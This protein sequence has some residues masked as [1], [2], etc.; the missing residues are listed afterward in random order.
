MLREQEAADTTAWQYMSSLDCVRQVVQQEGVAGLYR[1]LSASYYLGTVEA[2][3]RTRLR[4]APME[5]GAS[6]MSG[7]HSVSGRLRFGRA[8]WRLDAA[9][10]DY[11]F[12]GVRV[13]VSIIPLSS[14]IALLD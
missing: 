3:L 8:L 5:K 11:H 9:L 4:Q 7:S 1:G 13:R 6:S 12:K 10:D 14:R 2:V